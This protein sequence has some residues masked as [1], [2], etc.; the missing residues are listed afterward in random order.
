MS[1]ILI[2]VALAGCGDDNPAA[3]T[4]PAPVATK[5]RISVKMSSISA[6]SDCDAN[7]GPGEFYVRFVVHKTYEDGSVHEVGSCPEFLMVVN[8]GETL[9]AGDDLMTP[10][11][12]EMP[13]E[14]GARFS[15][16]WFI[17]EYDGGSTNS[18]NEHGFGAHE[19]DRNEGET[20]GPSGGFERY[21]KQ[22]DGYVGVYKFF[23]YSNY[24]D[25]RVT[26][27]YAVY[28]TP[29]FE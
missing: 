26:A 13:R 17:R 8:E 19:F 15:V 23:A 20:W 4:A 7:S 2:G 25:C 5:D 10:I 14:P 29:I 27:N 28:I 6:I 12:F 22:D 18:F 16:E 9:G 11:T 1:C 21:T 3:P 24:T